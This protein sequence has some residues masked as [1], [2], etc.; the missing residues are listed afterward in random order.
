MQGP[1]VVQTYG[2]YETGSSPE[3]LDRAA[4]CGSAASFDSNEFP[5]TGSPLPH[6]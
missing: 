1:D 6:A 5:F 4:L 2:K 3:S